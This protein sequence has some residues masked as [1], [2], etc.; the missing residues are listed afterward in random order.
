MQNR[1]KVLPLL[2]VLFSL[3]F[4][5]GVLQ[6]ASIKDRMAERI[7]AINVLKDQGLVG[8][9]N[10]GFLEFRTGQQPSQALI[11]DENNDR[12]SVYAAIAQK[13]GVSAQ[14][15]G[16]RRAKMLADNGKGGH[17]FQQADGTWYQK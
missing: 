8:E 17:W 15:V 4:A 13:E 1:H 14:L 16:Q 10:G 2:L 9:N 12:K 11:Q 6:A 7:P 5:A 3:V